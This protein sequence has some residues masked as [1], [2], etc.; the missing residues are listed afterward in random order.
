MDGCRA[1]GGFIVMDVC[2]SFS[3]IN[4]NNVDYMLGFESSGNDM[5]SSCEKI[6]LHSI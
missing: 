4:N 3:Y 5:S 1:V 6:K 2:T